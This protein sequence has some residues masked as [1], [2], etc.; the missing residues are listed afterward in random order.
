MSQARLFE[1]VYLLLEKGK[2]PATELAQRF[3]VSVRTIYRDV[4]A[5][6]SAGVPVYAIPGRSG[7]VALMDHYVL[8]RAALS[9]AEQEQLLTALRTLA[10][11]PGLGGEEALSKLSGLFQRKE[12]DW[13]EVDLSHWGDTAEDRD[14]FQ[15]L[16]EAIFS[17]RVIT[18]TYVSSY[19]QATSRRALP[20]RLVFKGQ[21]WYLQGFCLNK[22]AY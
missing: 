18:F 13:L 17:H 15:T 8:N 9:D 10:G 6:S 19:G 20:L 22:E 16:K 12:P 1:L 21:S 2:L 7:G 14:K 11:T 5:L 3:E 4:D